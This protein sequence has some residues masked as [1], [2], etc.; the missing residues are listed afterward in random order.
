MQERS[1]GAW[2]T[3]IS[4]YGLQNAQDT[5]NRLANPMILYPKG[6]RP[7]EPAPAAYAP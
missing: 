1:F 6:Q 2:R 3:T 7:T 5:L 4:V